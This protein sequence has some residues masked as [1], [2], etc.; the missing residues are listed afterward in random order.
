MEEVFRSFT[1]VKVLIP[2][3]KNTP[4]QVKV[5]QE[6]VTQ[7][8]VFKYHLKNVLKI[9]KVKVLIGGKIIKNKSK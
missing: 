9:L 2:H 3:C 7:V 8:K 6:N 4:L 1:E 5:L